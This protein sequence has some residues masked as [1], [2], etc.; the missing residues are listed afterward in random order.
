MPLLGDSATP[1]ELP[2]QPVAKISIGRLEKTLGLDKLACGILRKAGGIDEEIFVAGRLE[3]LDI[4][5]R[6]VGV[7]I[8]EIQGDQ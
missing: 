7:W 6:D 5:A 1:V 3:A 2:A 8:G 4:E